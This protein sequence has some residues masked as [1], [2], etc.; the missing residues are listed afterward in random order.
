MARN[1]TC[2]EFVKKFNPKKR[3]WPKD[4]QPKD[5]R[6]LLGNYRKENEK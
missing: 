2:E 1:E 6:L 3:R 4:K 5:R